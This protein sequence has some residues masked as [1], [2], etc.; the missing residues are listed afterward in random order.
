MN[1]FKAFIK[2]FEAPEISVER[3]TPGDLVVKSKLSPRS[4]TVAL[5]Q[6]KLIHKKGSYS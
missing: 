6:L 1:A 2:S 4:G 5:R 3:K